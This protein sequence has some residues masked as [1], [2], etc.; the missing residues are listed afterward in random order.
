MYR[1]PFLGAVGLAPA[2]KGAATRG[3]SPDEGRTHHGYF[4]INTKW[5]TTN[6]CWRCPDVS[7]QTQDTPNL[8]QS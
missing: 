2:R 4:A 6:V 1:I 7:A 5:T 8:P 3:I